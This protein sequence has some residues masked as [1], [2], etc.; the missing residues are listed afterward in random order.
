[1]PVLLEITRADG[2]AERM[3]VPVD[4]WLAGAR[5]T[6]VRVRA[7]PAITRVVIDPEERFPDI[8][9]ANQRWTP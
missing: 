5:R 4:V 8:D 6:A 1:M 9:R 2:S 3:T 7:T